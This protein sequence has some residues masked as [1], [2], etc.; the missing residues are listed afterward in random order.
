M[1]VNF[2]WHNPIRQQSNSVLGPV[3]LSMLICYF[4]LCNYVT[5][6]IICQ[7]QS[8][9]SKMINIM[10]VKTIKVLVYY[11]KIK[12]VESIALIE[13]QN[14]LFW[15]IDSKIHSLDVNYSK[16]FVLIENRIEE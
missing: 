13:N 4:F 12:R 7:M 10:F 2:I 9:R 8:K 3:D 14:N 11:L 6:T 1:C 16:N 15:E 5:V